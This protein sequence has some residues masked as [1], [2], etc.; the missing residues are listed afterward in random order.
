VACSDRFDAVDPTPFGLLVDAPTM[1]DP[2]AVRAVLDAH[3]SVLVAV[4]AHADID[5][6]GS[7]IGLGRTLSASTRIV[8]PDGVRSRAGRLAESLGVTVLDPAAVDVADA[9]CLVVLDAPSTARVA[10]LPVAEASG[11]VVVVDHHEPGDLDDLATAACV[12]T[13]AGATAALVAD[14]VREVGWPPDP[15]AAVALAAGLLDATGGLAAAADGEPRLLGDLLSAAGDRAEV[16]PPVLRRDRSFGSRVA[17]TKAVVRAS[18]YRADR[19]LVLTTAVS[20]EQTAAARALRDAGADVALVLSARE[21]TWV[22]GRA[23]PDAIHLPDDL[24]AP[25][26]ERHGGDG[27]G[28]AGAGVAKLDDDVE[29]VRSTALDCLETAL[30]GSLSPLS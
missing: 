14:V 10:P 28:H 12:D 30:G 11:D 4:H 20:G 17:A 25:L 3:D 19:T 22:V 27:G 5:A 8:A 29:R 6:L 26:V 2:S 9:A 16:L 7:A 21:R 24:F 23:D 1:S 13:D 15:T 18:G